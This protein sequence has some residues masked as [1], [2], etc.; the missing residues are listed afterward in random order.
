MATLVLN[1]PTWKV[2]EEGAKS[3]DGIL[4]TGVG[5]GYAIAGTLVGQ[6]K[7]GCIVVVLNKGRQLRAEGTLIRLEP[8]GRT[9]SGMQRYDVWIRDLQQTEY[10]PELLNRC[11]VGV[12]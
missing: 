2:Q 1:A 11:G 3:F 12:R 9:E 5:S 4:A 7:P 8:K 6:L 10:R